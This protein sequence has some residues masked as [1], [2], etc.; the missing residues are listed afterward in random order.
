MANAFLDVTEVPVTPEWFHIN[1]NA[2]LFCPQEKM[3]C[4]CLEAT[5]N[6]FLDVCSF[7]GANT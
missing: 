5:E 6:R 2:F 7:L 4:D 3:R 1:S